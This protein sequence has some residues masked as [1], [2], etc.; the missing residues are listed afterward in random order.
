[1]ICTVLKLTNIVFLT[2]P[3]YL[4]IAEYY[5]NQTHELT[6]KYMDSD[7]A[8]RESGFDTSSRFGPFNA[9]I[10][11]FN[12]VCLN[13]LLV[14]METDLAELYLMVEPRSPTEQKS[15]TDQSQQWAARAQ[16][17]KRLMNLYNWDEEDGLFYDY[18]FIR[19]ERRKYKF[20]TTFVPLWTGVA[21]PA[22]A[23]R[24]V[25]TG[26]GALEVRGGLAT[27]DQN[28]GCQWDM[29]Y[30]W[31]PLQLFAVEGMYRYGFVEEAERLAVNFGS[32]VLE[33]WLRT[34][35]MWEKY[36]AVKRDE[37]VELQY[38]YP[39]NEVGFGWTNGQ[40]RGL[41]LV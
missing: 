6:A 13:A 19:K 32:M 9:K 41:F 37:S 17:R 12:P 2:P 8:M 10:L 25:K 31:A 40:C 36:N 38:G 28:V 4:D 39:T 35:E 33:T 34:G 16:D 15:L 26:L 21:T 18:D 27:S 7:R 22:Q 29:P 5:D 30:A 3:L 11:D 20:G 14:Q 1:M 24:V 23:A